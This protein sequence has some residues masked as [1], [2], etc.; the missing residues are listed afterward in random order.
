[1]HTTSSASHHISKNRSIS[2]LCAILLTT[3]LF[4][5]REEFDNR[6]SD[7]V[8]TGIT[9]TG[10]SDVAEDVTED[11]ENS[12]IIE[13][14]GK[15]CT[16]ACGDNQY[17]FEGT[18]YTP[19]MLA[20]GTSHSCA[21]SEGTVKCWGSNKSGQL[22]A[23]YDP[24]K[25]VRST[26]TTVNLDGVPTSIYAGALQS[27]AITKNQDDRHELYCWGNHSALDNYEFDTSPQ[28]ITDLDDGTNITYAMAE[29]AIGTSHTCIRFLSKAVTS[30]RCWGNNYNGQLG[31][32]TNT[33]S[34]KAVI[35]ALALDSMQITAGDNFTCSLNGNRSVSCWGTNK[36]GQLGQS[37]TD[38]SEATTPLLIPNLTD[39]RSITSG[40]SNTCALFRNKTVQCWGKN[41]QGQLGD[42]TLEHAFSP[43]SQSP[44]LANVKQLAIGNAFTCALLESGEVHC[45]GINFSGELGL[46]PEN[47]QKSK[48]F[49]KN[50]HLE[51]VHQIAVGA[52]HICAVHGANKVSCWGYNEE[53]QVGG[54]NSIKKYHQP[55]EI[56]L[57]D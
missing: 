54:S 10:N 34:L 45:A 13:D 56:N 49:I 42:N 46:T 53:L 51:N 48:V 55:H 9:D 43:T 21:L 17:C 7:A 16:T 20:L 38:Q 26:P 40:Q 6:P 52:N 41:D 25:P 32:G 3:S 23:D 35:S 11:A 1:M 8:D 29:L 15:T 36:E 5:C 27:C 47:P 24:S 44:A 14:T 50:P 30:V 39:V 22:G 37:L 12:D 33:H 18:C 19:P 28:K 4:A 31:D 2:M 57:G